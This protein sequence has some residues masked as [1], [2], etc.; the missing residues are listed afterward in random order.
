[1]LTSE[2]PSGRPEKY[3]GIYEVG[4]F[5][6]REFRARLD[7]YQ[8]LYTEHKSW[9]RSDFVVSGTMQQHWKIHQ[10]IKGCDE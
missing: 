8:V 7:L 2:G 5:Y 10:W 3:R 1:M 4:A 9:S 6:R